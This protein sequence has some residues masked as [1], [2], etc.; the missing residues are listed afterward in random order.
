MGS[1]VLKE[2]QQFEI[3]V[4]GMIKVNTKL[5]VGNLSPETTAEDLR[6]LFSKKGSV[7]SVELI[8]DRGTGKSKGFAYVEMISVGD[9][10]KAVSEF[11]GYRLNRSRIKVSPANPPKPKPQRK[12][13]PGY[14]EYESYN[15]SI[16]K[17]TF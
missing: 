10:G 7:V 4:G 17:G 16:R 8:M 15:K 12:Q 6:W 5:H 3:S 2:V 13:K 1:A 11:N 9:A 14:V